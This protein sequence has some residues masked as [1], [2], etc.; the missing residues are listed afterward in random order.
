[1]SRL[2]STEQATIGEGRLTEIRLRASPVPR[3]SLLLRLLWTMWTNVRLVGASFRLL[4]AADGILFTGAPPLLIHLMA[5]LKVLWRGR[6]VYR[7][8]DFHPECLIAAQERPSH[9]LGLVLALTKFWRRRI[10]AFEVLGEDQ[11]A[12][13]RQVGIPAERIA[14]VRDGSP[15]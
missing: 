10:D 1:A 8:T 11:Q 6:L 5:P 14:L 7:I 15:V 2:A 3:A 13:L 9:L 4:R 12:R